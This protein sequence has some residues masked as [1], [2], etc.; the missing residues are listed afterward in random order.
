[1]FILMGGGTLVWMYSIVSYWRSKRSGSSLLRHASEF[2][3]DWDSSVIGLV[4]PAMGG[5]ANLAD[6]LIVI[7]LVGQAFQSFPSTFF[8]RAPPTDPTTASA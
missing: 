5:S 7:G 3:L 4:L 6:L 8:H 1:M 2:G